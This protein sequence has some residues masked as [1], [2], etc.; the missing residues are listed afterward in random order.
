MIYLT[1]I[2]YILI[3]ITCVVALVDVV[4]MAIKTKATKLNLDTIKNDSEN[5]SIDKDK[6]SNEISK[7]KEN[8]N[9]SDIENIE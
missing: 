1:N 3:T 2:D 6:I 9:S 4:I 5:N 8:S 7:E